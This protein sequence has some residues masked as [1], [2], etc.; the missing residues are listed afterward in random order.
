ML[1]HKINKNLNRIPVM[2]KPFLRKAA[3][4]AQTNEG[5]DAP[6]AEKR[7]QVNTQEN[8]NTGAQEAEQS[9]EYKGVQESNP[10]SQQAENPADDKTNKKVKNI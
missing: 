8:S 10:Q 9:L 6:G 1:K 4:P 2:R 3:A 5:A 7:E